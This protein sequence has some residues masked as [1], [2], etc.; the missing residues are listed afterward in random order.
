MILL[1]GATGYLGSAIARELIV[2]RQSFRVLVRDPTRLAFDP[3]QFQ[4]EVA[5]GD[6]LDHDALRAAVQGASAVIHT[7]ALVK[8]WVRERSDFH[9][10]NVNGL[11]NLLQAASRAGV[12]RVVYTSSFMAL[13]PSTDG[14]A[15][16]ELR[17]AGPFASEYEESKS[18]ALEW[19]RIEGL[20]QF[21][22]VAMLPGVI[23]GPGPLTSG[24]LMGGM[25]DRYLAGKFP[26]LLG[27]GS[28]RWSFAFNAGVVK[29]HLTALEKGRP[30]EA[31]LLGGDNRSLN[32]FF[33]VVAD[34][35]HLRRSI[36]HIPFAAAKLAGAVELIR[37]RLFSRPPQ[38]TPGIVEIFK[39]D[40]VYSSAKSIRELDYSVAPLEEGLLRTLEGK[41]LHH[42]LR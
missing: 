12:R 30:G 6:L 17:H 33:R 20:R 11:Q 31:Y 13:G 27:S 34:I 21:P 2:R 4:C 40:W 35:T 3:A 32:D 41:T 15:D 23:Y 16:E 28:Q 14:N 37:A 29:A 24:N 1:T 7:A 38:L 36:R 18:Q 39:R 25:I 8:M 19:L 5:V 26:G 9:R 42:V 10:V 22:V